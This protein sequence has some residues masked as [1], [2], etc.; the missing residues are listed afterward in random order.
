M[1]AII[2]EFKLGPFKLPIFYSPLTA[3]LLRYGNSTRKSA[4]LWQKIIDRKVMMDYIKS[5][6]I[7]NNID[8]LISPTFPFPAIPYAIPGKILRMTMKYLKNIR[9]TCCNSV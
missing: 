9:L 7:S 3:K 5:Q 4:G 1:L 6:W 8:V 2:I